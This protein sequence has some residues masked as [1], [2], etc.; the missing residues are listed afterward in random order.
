[1]RDSLPS[2]E[3]V[4]GS[5]LKALFDALPFFPVVEGQLLQMRR[6]SEFVLLESVGLLS[7]EVIPLEHVDFFT[8]NPFVSRSTFRSLPPSD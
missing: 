5:R 7:E 4:P 2:V 1:M 6:S 8:N 3:K